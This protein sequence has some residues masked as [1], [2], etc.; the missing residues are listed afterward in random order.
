MTS[1]GHSVISADVL[2]RHAAYATAEVL[3]GAGYGAETPSSVQVVVDDVR[4]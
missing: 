3:V 2:A 1:D 4:R